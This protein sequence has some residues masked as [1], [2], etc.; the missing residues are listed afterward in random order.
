MILLRVCN[1]PIGLMGRLTLG[2]DLDTVGSLGRL[3]SSIWILAGTLESPTDLTELFSLVA[4][5]WVV[6]LS[7]GSPAAGGSIVPAAALFA[8]ANSIARARLHS[9]QVP[10]RPSALDLSA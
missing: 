7:G 3:V 4:G 2:S 8:S 9:L 1:P 5:G 6:L 10:S